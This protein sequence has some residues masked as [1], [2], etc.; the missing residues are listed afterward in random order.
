MPTTDNIIRT[1]NR[2][3]LR[4]GDDSR[5]GRYYHWEGK[6]YISVTNALTHGLPKPALMY[7][8]SWFVADHVA[9]NLDDVVGFAQKMDRG[10]FISYLKNLP[11]QYRDKAGDIGS[12]VHEIAERYVIDP[13]SIDLS[14]VEDDVV[15]AKARQF[16]D[17]MR[18]VKPDVYAIEG[19]VFNREH[20]YAGAFDFIFDINYPDGMLAGRFVVD[21]K[22]GSGIYESDAL[23]QNG[24]T[25]GDF[26]AV[27]D[28]EVPMPEVDGAFCLHLMK[29]KWKLIPVVTSPEAFRVFLNALAI[30]KWNHKDGLGGAKQSVG[31]PY[32][33]SGE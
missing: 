26:I 3:D 12:L 25:N 1:P 22:T 16:V 19:V 13:D 24:Y 9:D 29:T 4:T 11:F 8:A 10:E 32:L 21:V 14:Q 33:S 2:E 17:F 31:V 5:Q 28:K 23:Q 7:W 20:G 15:Q 18:T 27:G 30:A 6:P